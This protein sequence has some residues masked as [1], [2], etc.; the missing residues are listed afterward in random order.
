MTSL[1]IAEI[2]G[3]THSNVMRDIRNILEQLEE[4]HKFNFELMFK[5]TK[6][7]NNAERKDPYYLRMLTFKVNGL[8]AKDNTVTEKGLMAIQFYL[9]M[10]EQKK[11]ELENCQTAY[12]SCSEVEEWEKKNA[13][14][15][16]SFDSGGVVEFLPIE[17]FS[18]DAKIEKGGGIKGMLISMCDC[19]CEDEI[20]EIVSSNDEIRKLRDALNKYL[21]S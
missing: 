15:S 19:A 3:K 17:M 13:A 2:T 4:K 18:K 8:I 12:M 7:G 9:D 6:L 16:V 21:E 5:I 14:A 10:I 11:P 1:Q 20:S